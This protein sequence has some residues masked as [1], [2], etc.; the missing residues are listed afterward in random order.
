MIG[1]PETYIEG[2]KKHGL[3]RFIYTEPSDMVEEY[4]NKKSLVKHIEH[5]FGE[6]STPF[7]VK[8]IK[9]FPAADVVEVV[10]CKDCVH[11]VELH[12]RVM[13]GRTARGNGNLI[14]GLIATDA[15][16]FCGHGERGGGANSAGRVKE[17]DT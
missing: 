6:I 2:L 3:D 4:V 9:D 16:D 14:M 8:E 12:G 15:D 1:Q 10:R 7:V 17:A 11:K 13:C 5:C